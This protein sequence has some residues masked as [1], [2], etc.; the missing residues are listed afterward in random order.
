[1]VGLDAAFADRPLATVGGVVVAAIYVLLAR[2]FFLLAPTVIAGL[3][4]AC[5]VASWAM[6]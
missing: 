1:M 2:H 5:V 4:L 6:A 3:A